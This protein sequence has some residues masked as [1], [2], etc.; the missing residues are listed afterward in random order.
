[1]AYIKGNDLIISKAEG[2]AIAASKTCEI[3]MNCELKEISSPSSGAFKSFIAG[4]KEWSVSL[5]YMVPAE[6]TT[7]MNR[8]LSVGKTYTLTCK[9]RGSETDTLSGTAICTEC[10]ITASRGNMLT[11]NFSFKGTGPL[12]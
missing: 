3:N 9:V 12:E 1:M 7:V 4:R 5:Q 10:K 11:G 8:I 6:G 2:S